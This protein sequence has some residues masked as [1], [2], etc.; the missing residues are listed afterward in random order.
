LILVFRLDVGGEG[1]AGVV[2]GD[3]GAEAGPTEAHLDGRTRGDLNRAV[4]R[5]GE[6][7]QTLERGVIRDHRH[8]DETAASLRGDVVIDDYI[9]LAEERSGEENGEKGKEA[10]RSEG[11]GRLAV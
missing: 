1:V 11:F 10:H 2:A 8:R 4:R 5:K 9:A 6:L 3:D 7:H